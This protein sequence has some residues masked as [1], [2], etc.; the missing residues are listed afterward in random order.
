MIAEACQLVYDAATGMQ[1]NKKSAARWSARVRSNQAS[2][3]RA[4]SSGSL[5][6][7]QSGALR[8]LQRLF[9]DSATFMRQFHQNGTVASIKRFFGHQKDAGEFAE[10]G[11]RLDELLLQLSV[12]LHGSAPAAA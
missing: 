1:Q 6:P 9:L 7:K 8:E 2:V 3:V 11:Q 12:D 4:A 5:T 10:F